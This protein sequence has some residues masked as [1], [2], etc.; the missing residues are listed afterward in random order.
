MNLNKKEFLTTFGVP[1]GGVGRLRTLGLSPSGRYLAGAFHDW[2]MG[3]IWDFANPQKPT[4]LATERHLGQV[5]QLVFSADGKT[6]VTGDTDKF[7]KI[8]DVATAKEQATL[9]GH[10]A[11]IARV[12]ISPDGRTVASSSDD[13]SVRLWNVATR[14]EVARFA[15]HGVMYQ[16]TFSPDGS[17]L[18]LTIRGATDRPPR[19]LVWRAP[20]LSV[21]DEGK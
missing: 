3:L 4:R 19:T 15:G 12:D 21:A 9:L 14:R 8:W 11:G 6:L 20:A 18:L 1:I 16:V 5:A 17:A 2:P 13:G 7:I 10:W